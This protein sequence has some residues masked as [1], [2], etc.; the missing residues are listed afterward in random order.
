MP[1]YNQYS[2]EPGQGSSPPSAS[3]SGGAAA[4]GG[5]MIGGII[6]GVNGIVSNIIS[7]NDQMHANRENNK[8]FWYSKMFDNWYNSPKEVVARLKAAGI[9]P[10]VAYGGINNPASSGA[11]PERGVTK[12]DGD[13]VSNGVNS[14]VSLMQLDNMKAQR[15]L[16]TAQTANV[17]A[18]TLNKSEQSGI[19]TA[20]KAGLWTRLFSDMA[21]S[22]SRRDNYAAA[23]KRSNSMLAGD[24]RA[25]ETENT[26]KKSQTV[27]TD[28]D[29]FR[30]LLEN[31]NLPKRLNA[32]LTESYARTIKL[33]EEGNEAQARAEVAQSL[34]NVKKTG[35]G[36][37]FIGE[38]T[39]L[40]FKA[41]ENRG[42]FKS[43]K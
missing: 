6:S 4:G 27:G 39:T 3:S 15:G 8:Q 35:A 9:N 38:L 30:K 12:M 18:D 36:S 19:P 11:P 25:Q 33:V 21:E 42:L 5:G 22:Q 37:S 17:N 28:R 23:T 10:A 14:A 1:G 31:N 13:S 2:M 34:K 29:N 43:P 20:T 7:R 26:L 41:L 32:E 40:F 24:L 16:I